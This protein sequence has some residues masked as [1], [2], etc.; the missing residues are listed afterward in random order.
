VFNEASLK[1]RCDFAV[2][3]RVRGFPPLAPHY[4]PGMHELQ[5]ALRADAG[6][7][8]Q[9]GERE[10]A[11]YRLATA[12][13]ATA[14]MG[15]DANL[16]VCRAAHVDFNAALD[17]IEEAANRQRIDVSS[18]PQLAD[19][20]GRVSRKD[21]FGYVDSFTRTRDGLWR[22]PLG[23]A[24]ADQSAL[25]HWARQVEIIR[26]FNVDQVFFILVIFDQHTRRQNDRGPPEGDD[27][28]Q[29]DTITLPETIERMTGVIDTKAEAA[30]R[31][32][33]DEIMPRL[34]ANDW[35]VFVGREVTP[36][37]RLAEGLTRA[38]GDLRRA[39]RVLMLPDDPDAAAAGPTSRP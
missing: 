36:A 20:A 7:F 9:G 16:A 26:Q 27:Q 34:L 21:P 18:A 1:R 28:W 17:F 4:A 30:I 12:L 32:Q 39:T 31:A 25:D 8:L 6:R 38:R 23:P 14:H 29:P 5:L 11:V 22:A 33:F 3:V 10:A 2:F 24:P 13:R 37:A 35:G 15:G 19:A